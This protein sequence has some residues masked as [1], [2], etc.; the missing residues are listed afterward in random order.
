MAQKNSL[1]Q[2]NNHSNQLYKQFINIQFEDETKI[3]P[4]SD[5]QNKEFKYRYAILNNKNCK[6]ITA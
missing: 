2:L 1:F 3:L 5:L 4:K 6:N